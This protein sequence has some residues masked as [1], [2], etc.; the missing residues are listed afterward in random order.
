VKEEIKDR[1]EKIKNG[2][3]PEG[4]K[5]TKVGIIP[6]DWKM[7]QIDKLVK[8]I[9]NPVDVDK[10]KKYKQIGIRSHG[11]GI[12]YK[13]E[14]S[15]LE[16]GNKSV[17]WIEPECFIVN[18]VFAWELAVA[19]TTQKEIGFIASHRFPMYKPIDGKLDIDYLTYFFKSNIG[20]NLLQLASPGGAGRNKTLGQKEFSELMIPTSIIREQQKIAQ[21]L[22]TWDK[23][24]QLKEQLIKQ[25]KEQKRGLMQKLLTGGVRLPGFDGE[26]RELKVKDIAKIYLGLT[27]TP[28]YVSKGIPFLSVKDI[29][30][31][32]INF[33]NV[34]YI[35]ENEY[36]SSTSNSKPG[37][38][39]VLFGRVGTLGN[40]I[41]ITEDIE[42]CI[43]VSLGYLKI[44][45]SNVL[46][47]FIMHWMN[48]ELF[49]K[50]VES[51]IAGSSQKNLNTG[52][53]KEFDF[54][55]PPIEEQRK[56]SE[57]LSAKDK[58]INLL[59]QELEA[60]KLQKKGLMQLLLTGI[61]R[62]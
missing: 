12:F 43:F 24:I 61:V 18:I 54:S 23:G 4:Y 25:K 48:S 13:D 20:A 26:W 46:N 59:E 47:Y 14:V 41:I 33:D 11:K 38:G 50:Q 10:D 32:R 30:G 16:L 29:N 58:Q 2:E 15:G 37:K 44:L 31:G 53:L 28:T 19:K 45:N 39:D 49:K 55:L 9:S 21:I 36:E 62:V 34:K 35:S 42:F 8:R 7:I 51:K 57:I 27:Y 52:W 22:C 1:I 3:V 40:P 60:L 5:K 17:F 56:I 6:S